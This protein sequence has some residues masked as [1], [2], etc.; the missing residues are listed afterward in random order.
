MKDSSK[1]KQALIREL[2]S[3]KERITELEQ[4]ESERKRAEEMLR[5]LAIRNEAI[6]AAVPD[7][8]ME[9]D[10][11]KRYIWANQA[12]MRFFG[13][14]V[15]GREASYYFEGEQETYNKVQPLFDGAEDVIYIE[16][17]QRRKD[18]EKRLLSWWCK[19]LKDKQGLVTGALS[20]GRD[21]TERKQ[22][23]EALFGSEQRYRA[24][25]DNAG[26][27][28]FKTDNTG[29]FTF[30]NPAGIRIMGYEKEEV[31]G[32]HYPSLI[33][34]DKREETMK[35]FG[36]QF[37]KG[38]QNT[39]F[40]YPVIAKDGHEIW[41][42]Q[43]T[44]LIFHD[45][46]AVAFQ[47]VARDITDRKR[48]E[49]EIVILAE[50][51]QLIGSTLDIDEVYE[52]VADEARKLIRIDSLNVNL[53]NFQENTMRV[54][55]ASGLS[56]D[57]RRQGDPLI[58][59]GSLSE[60]VMRARTS[61]RIQPASTDEIVGQFPRLSPIFQAGLR[62]IIC[63]P[64]V[65][66]DEV[67]GALHFRSK[68]ENAY[69]EQDLRLAE[70]IGTQIAGAIANAQLY[71]DLKKTENSLRRSEGRFRSLFEQAAVGVA[72]IV[73][74][75]GQFITVNRR[76]CEIV[77][78]AEEELLATTFQSITYPEDLHLHDE[79]T[80]MM[81][82]GEIGHYSLEKRYFWKDGKIVWVNITV[83]PLWKPGDAPGRNMIVVEDIT[84]RKRMES[85]L[86]KSE[87]EYRE[88]SIKLR[89]AYLWMS[90]KKDELESQKYSES[91][92]FLTADDGQIWGF[93]EEA[94][95]ITTKSRSEIQVCNI[96]DILIFQEGQAFM[97]FIHKVRP[98]ISHLTTARFKNQ[99]EDGPVYKAKLTRI[100]VESK[101]LF[102]IVL[103]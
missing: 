75:T 65:Y 54:A 56:I 38:L 6:L 33:R 58:L 94:L 24:L 80:Q 50:I 16:S 97:D 69:T 45:R 55:Y 43:N 72:E 5:M 2:T 64:L 77:G 26:D 25:V 3:L 102:Y 41:L 83:S 51:R 70:R 22:A 81:L 1:T 88:L 98:R 91:I 59:E 18:G 30:V 34:P 27:I 68:K 39:Y 78:R 28:V 53:Y 66:R 17:W 63:V 60:A 8:I 36:L 46:K 90:Q 4:S 14:D 44:Q 84:E 7:I 74:E 76:L 71:S 87:K 19:V 47:A 20:T 86:L 31:I 32:R 96:Q 82:A 13:E 10:G 15:I 21:I 35:F 103:Y 73:M 95:D 49:Q 57:G 61:L 89:D 48:A 12:G 99:M 42:G 11:C 37:A 93:T 40:E 79:K 23:E 9:V 100:V 85:E 67:I 62:S 101:R 92:V 29:H 52:R